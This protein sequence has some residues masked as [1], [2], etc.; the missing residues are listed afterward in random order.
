MSWSFLYPLL[1]GFLPCLLIAKIG[2]SAPSTLAAHLYHFGIATITTASILQGILEIAGT[3]SLYPGWLGALGVAE[4][5][6]GIAVYLFSK[7]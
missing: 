1:L 3:G 6:A 2:L 5:F 7:R 4:I